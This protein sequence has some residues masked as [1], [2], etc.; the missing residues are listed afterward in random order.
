MTLEVF[1]P[2]PFLERVWERLVLF[3]KCLVEL[4][5]EATWFWAF[6]CWEVLVYWLNLLTH[7][8]SI[9]ICDFWFGLDMVYVSKNL[10]VYPNIIQ[11]HIAVDSN[12]LW[13]YFC[14]ISCHFSFTSNLLDC[15]AFISKVL[16]T[17]SPSGGIMFPWFFMSLEVCIAVLPSEVIFTFS[18]LY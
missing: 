7:C 2:P 8:W 6:L 14:G 12:L 9:Q 15:S 4:T 11:Q 1:P 3:F 17:L 5:N 10:S 13:T 18:C 16:S